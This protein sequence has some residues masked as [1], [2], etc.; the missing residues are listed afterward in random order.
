MIRVRDGQSFDRFFLGV[1]RG[2][3]N[4]PRFEIDGKPWDGAIRFEDGHVTQLLEPQGRFGALDRVDLKKTQ[5]IRVVGEGKLV[6]IS[7]L[8]RTLAEL[9]PTRWGAPFAAG[10]LLALGLVFALA[11]IIAADSLGGGLAGSLGGLGGR[12][13]AAGAIATAPFWA[14]GTIAVYLPIVTIA[15]AIPWAIALGASMRR[16][17]PLEDEDARGKR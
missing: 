3:I 16:V 1:H 14:R 2:L 12:L 15:A 6:G 9:L 13:F 17:V 11:L 4:E 10:I 8:G 7:L 5:S